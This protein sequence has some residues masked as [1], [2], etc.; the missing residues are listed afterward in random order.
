MSC[1]THKTTIRYFFPFKVLSN[2]YF[3]SD[4]RVDRLQHQITKSER[5]L[6][7]QTILPLLLSASPTAELHC[8]LKWRR[9]Q[10]SMHISFVP[11]HLNKSGDSSRL[12]NRQQALSVV[13]Q[14]VECSRGAASRLHVVGVLHG[15]DD[16]RHHLRGAHDGVARS[17]FLGELVHHHRCFVYNNLRGLRAM[18]GARRRKGTTF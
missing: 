5:V 17:L 15:P 10:I 4:R 18:S 13:G 9:K 16:G 6:A 3:K 12:E 8:I 11:E 14:V 7:S 2:S 1:R